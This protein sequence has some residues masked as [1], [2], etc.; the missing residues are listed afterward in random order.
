MSDRLPQSL[1]QGIYER[2]EQAKPNLY[3]NFAPQLLIHLLLSAPDRLE[4]ECALSGSRRQR[5]GV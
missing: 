4:I 2:S 5:G 1:P 3:A